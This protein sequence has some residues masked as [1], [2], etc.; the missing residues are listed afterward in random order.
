MP[1]EFNQ[2]QSNVPSLGSF[3]VSSLNAAA[4]QPKRIPMR[5]TAKFK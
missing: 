2:A 1:D 3:L 5:M 4:E